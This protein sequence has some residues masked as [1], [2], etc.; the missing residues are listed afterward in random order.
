MGRGQ[1]RLGQ[2]AVP[3]GARRRRACSRWR[4]RSWRGAASSRR[5]AMRCCAP[6]PC[7]RTAAAPAPSWPTGS[8]RSSPTSR[9]AP[10]TSR[11]TSP[12]PSGRRSRRCADKL[13]AVAVGQGGDRRGDQGDAGGARPQDAAAGAGGAR[14]GVRPRADAVARRRAR[15]VRPRDGA[16]TT[17]ARVAAGRLARV[18]GY[19]LALR[20]RR[21]SFCRSTIGRFRIS[22]RRGY[23]SAGRALAWH[24]RGQRFDPAYLHHRVG[25]RAREAG[26]R[27]EVPFV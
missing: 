16:G 14:A 11:S 21:P 23:S 8:R 9:R 7:S 20:W 6:A 15:A 2:R 5:R 22:F 13:A 12:T 17:G 26:T 10:T 25:S 4:R 1:A 18:P 3:E 24:A 19:N 27:V